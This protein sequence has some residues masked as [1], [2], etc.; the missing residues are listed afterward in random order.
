MWG[1]YPTTV[2]TM[3]EARERMN[4]VSTLEEVRGVA[5]PDRQML[6]DAM[7][8]ILA[9]EQG[10]GKLYW[11]YTQ[12][13]SSPELREKWQKFGKETEVHRRIAE[14]VLV[15][16][17]GDP[18]YKS[19]AARDHERLADC[20]GNVESQ[21]LAGD[22]IRLGNLAMSED[23]SRLL[24]KGMHRIAL[25]IKDAPTAKLFWDA[26]KIVGPRKD[27]HVA[28]NTTMYQSYFEKL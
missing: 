6:L 8:G 27:G 28:W 20:L 5:E 2:N 25:S 24:W 13:T 11:Q 15:A 16:L 12:Q 23:I 21:G 3:A 14:R 10:V 4:I 1:T 9:H 19:T 26:A 7:S 22:H 17:G 18:A